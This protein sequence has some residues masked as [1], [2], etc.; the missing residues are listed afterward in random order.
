MVPRHWVSLSMNSE[1]I[2]FIVRQRRPFLLQTHLSLPFHSFRFLIFKSFESYLS[3]ELVSFAQIHLKPLEYCFSPTIQH[4]FQYHFHSRPK[5]HAFVCASC[6]AS[7]STKA[8]SSCQTNQRPR[9]GQ[10]KVASWHLGAQVWRSEG[11]PGQ[12]QPAKV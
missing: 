1:H 3:N 6:G 4:V 10:K 5:G 12:Q 2:L 7:T 8:P 9:K 11:L